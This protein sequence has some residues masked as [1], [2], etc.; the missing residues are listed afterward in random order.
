MKTISNWSSICK[1]TTPVLFEKLHYLQVCNKQ[2]YV[3]ISFSFSYF[4]PILSMSAWSYSVKQES[5]LPYMTLWPPMFIATGMCR[6]PCCFSMN[7][8]SCCRPISFFI[9][10]TWHLVYFKFNNNTMCTELWTV[11]NK[12]TIRLWVNEVGFFS[13]AWYFFWNKSAW[14]TKNKRK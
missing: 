8:Q 12:C 3:L 13:F 1:K 2:Y 5:I 4:L 6:D 10:Y 7:K 9:M 11:M 14:C